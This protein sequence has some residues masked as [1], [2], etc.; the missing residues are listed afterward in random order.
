MPVRR[1]AESRLTPVNE[2]AHDGAWSLDGGRTGKGNPMKL[3]REKYKTVEGAR[4]RMA[5]ENGIAKGE[6]MR[7]YK[8]KI[9]RYSVIEHDG[10]Y[11]VQRDNGAVDA[12]F[13][14]KLAN[15]SLADWSVR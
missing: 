1:R 7:G 6:Y 15:Y 8:R 10:S 2:C 11:R 12:T 13:E 9:Y 5:F 3:L 4:K 14:A